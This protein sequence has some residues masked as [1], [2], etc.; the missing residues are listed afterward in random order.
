MS[1]SYIDLMRH[2]ETTGGFAFRGSLDDALTDLGRARMQ[3][4]HDR[5]GPWQQII[6]SPLRRCLAPARDWSRDAG[7]PL[8]EE[9][10]LREMH[11]GTWE[12]RTAADLMESEPEALGKFWQDPLNHIPPGAEPLVDFRE[13]VLQA[14]QEALARVEAGPQLLVTHGGVIRLILL[15]V[16]QRPLSDLLKLDVPHAC[17]Y[18][19]HLQEGVGVSSVSALGAVDMEVESG[20]CAK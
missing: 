18:R 6:S 14:W 11:F 16:Q 5:H 4:G 15:H 19:I 1:S 7:I 12:G 10:R 8:Q 17:V 2:G 3:A 13:R 20:D 9:S